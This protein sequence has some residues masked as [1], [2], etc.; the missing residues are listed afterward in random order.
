MVFSS[1]KR[2]CGNLHLWCRIGYMD[3]NN[4]FKSIMGRH[5]LPALHL[6]SRDGLEFDQQVLCP[7]KWG[8]IDGKDYW[9]MTALKI[10][11]WKTKP[12]AWVRKLLVGLLRKMWSNFHIIILR[13]KLL[14]ESYK[15]GFR[16]KST[17]LYNEN[18]WL[19]LIGIN[20]YL[21]HSK[22]SNWMCNLCMQI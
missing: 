19:I 7:K 15:N 10:G 6:P 11:W 22:S 9:K 8:S 13:A 2:C 16:E 18:K 20:W 5:R 14:G 1:T 3:D 17:V 21:Y 4:V 12:Y